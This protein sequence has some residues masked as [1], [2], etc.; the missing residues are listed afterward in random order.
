[1]TSHVVSRVS[2]KADRPKP[3]FGTFVISSLRILDPKV[4]VCYGC[5]E[6]LKPGGQSP[7]APDELVVVTRIRRKYF[8]DGILQQSPDL[9]NVYHPLNPNCVHE[10]HSFFIPG[11]IAVPDDLKAH[12]SNAHRQDIRQRLGANL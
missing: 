2:S 12:L 10:Q 1:M 5:K 7:G 8:K 9:T 3:A 4:S 6:A 11:L